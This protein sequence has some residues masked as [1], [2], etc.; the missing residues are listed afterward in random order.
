MAEMP[1]FQAVHTLRAVREYTPDPI[2]RSYMDRVLRA[3]TMA[4]SPE[5]TQPWDFVVLSDLELRRQV[6]R[7]MREAYAGFKFRYAH[8]ALANM[9]TVPAIILVFWN[10]DRA[11]NAKN[12]PDYRQNPDGT[13]EDVVPS[14]ARGS[15]I[16]PACQNMMLAANALGLGSLFTTFMKKCEPDIKRLLRIPPR[17]SL[18]A[19]IFVGFPARKLGPPR[20][21]PVEQVSHDNYWDAGYQPEEASPKPVVRT[22]G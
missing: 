14:Q 10:P 20:R 11:M 19:A 13:I 3:G 17:M 6:Q 18:T 15:S 8:V 9:D 1:L 22:K 21:M 2:P 5:N 7:Y 4:C 12:A 16:F